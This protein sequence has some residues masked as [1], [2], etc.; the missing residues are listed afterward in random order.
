MKAKR[1]SLI[2]L[3]LII[4]VAIA[5]ISINAIMSYNSP[6]VGGT[7]FPWY[8]TIFF[9]GIYYFPLIMVSL[10]VYVVLWVKSKKIGSSKE[11]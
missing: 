6:G 4:V 1:I 2:I 9:T 11:Q 7:S 8:A 10:V 3:L 5:H